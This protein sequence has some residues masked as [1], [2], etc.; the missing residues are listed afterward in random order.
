MT[1][2]HG[3]RDVGAGP[4]D[5]HLLLALDPLGQVV[6]LV[7]LALPGGQRVGV[8]GKAGGVVEVL[9][10]AQRHPRLARVRVRRKQRQRPAVLAGRR[11]VH[12]G[13]HQPL[14]RL[15]RARLLLWIG[16]RELARVDVG[17]HGD[18]HV[19]VLGRPLGGRRD[20]VELLL[21]G[22]VEEGRLRPLG[23]ELHDR[24]PAGAQHLLVDRL[25]E[26]LGGAR[27]LDHAHVALRH[28]CRVADEDLRE[29]LCA[30]V[31]H[32]AVTFAWS[33]SQR[34]SRRSSVSSGW[35]DT[36]RMLPW[37]TATGWPSTSASTSTSSPTSSTQGARMKIA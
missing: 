4:L 34:C 35:K 29:R 7:G 2:A 22:Q 37:R 8:G 12:R 11:A 21:A 9:V 20:P 16:L 14:A 23:G 1:P 15:L 28:P 25:H 32:R 30:A 18:A 13:L 26:H 24:Q 6:D 10:V 36:A 19:G 33:S 27:G 31:S 5:V 17:H 3:E